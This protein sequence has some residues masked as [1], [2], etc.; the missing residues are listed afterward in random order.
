MKIV[1]IGAGYVGLVSGVC[2]SEIGHQV[3]CIDKNPDRVAA[4]EVGR[5]PIY[6]PGLEEMMARN[7]SAGRLGFAKDVESAVKGAD[8]VFICVGTPEDPETGQ[9]NLSYVLAAA[10]EIAHVIGSG[11]VVVTK[12]TVPVGTNER[13]RAAIQDEV[14]GIDVRVASNPEFL[15]EG[16]AIDDFMMPDRIVV[17]VDNPE[18]AGIMQEIYRP[19]M[20]LASR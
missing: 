14:P 6:E 19:L 10:R 13:V 1:M 7:V 12:S 9:A 15:R 11:A 8:A 2:F 17:G 16:S 3:I 20:K 4:L 18:T 5:S